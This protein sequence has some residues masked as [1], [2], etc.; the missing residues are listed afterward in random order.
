MTEL[1]EEYCW[2]LGDKDGTSRV[3]Q[4]LLDNALK[5]VDKDGRV[6]VRSKKQQDKLWISILNDGPPIPKEQ[7][8]LIWER[9]YKGDR[10]RGQDKKGVGLGLVI[11][12]EILK[13]HDETITVQSEEGKMVEFRFS[14]TLVN[15]L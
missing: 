5:F 6:I 2:I 8:K 7:Q 9:F 14:M 12:K 11:V 3:I 15:H 4:N 13:Q 1:D 10:S